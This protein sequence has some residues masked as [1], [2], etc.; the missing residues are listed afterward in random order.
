MREPDGAAAAPRCLRCC[1]QRCAIAVRPPFA[2]VSTSAIAIQRNTCGL[3]ALPYIRDASLRP[4]TLTPPSP[5]Q[6]LDN[7]YVLSPA[8]VGQRGRPTDVRSQ[9]FDWGGRVGIWGCRGTRRPVVRSPRHSRNPSCL[10]AVMLSHRR[11]RTLPTLL[12][13]LFCNWVILQWVTC[14]CLAP[15]TLNTL[16]PRHDQT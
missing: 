12:R 14:A 7:P 4:P 16:P 5:L 13:L 3:T 15:Q 6:L 2:L 8:Q 10:P 9:R 11:P 1:T